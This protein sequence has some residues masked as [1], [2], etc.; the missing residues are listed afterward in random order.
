MD[1]AM[2]G[3]QFSEQALKQSIQRQQLGIVRPFEILQ[4]QEIYIKSRLDYLK[5]VSSYNKAQYAY[6][7]AIGNTL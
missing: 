7:V 4:A 1:I 2:A 6:Y 5:A 3:G